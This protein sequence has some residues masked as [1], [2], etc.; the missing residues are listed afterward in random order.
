MLLSF[1]SPLLRD[2]LNGN[3]NSLP[4]ISVPVKSENISMLLKVLETGLVVS[5]NKNVFLEVGKVANM[6][7]IAFN[8]TD[9]GVNSYTDEIE[10][11]YTFD[12]NHLKIH[13]ALE[14]DNHLENETM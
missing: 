1:Y 10:E 11:P 13:Q 8:E 9:S 3:S 6:L 2:V 12:D 5:G 7:G 4:G 14:G